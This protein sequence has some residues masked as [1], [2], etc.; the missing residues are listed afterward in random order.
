MKVKNNETRIGM[1][2]LFM[3]MALILLM[4]LFGCDKSSQ[5]K[6]QIKKPSGMS[7]ELYVYQICKQA[8]QVRFMP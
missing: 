3:I 7:N 4:G 6:T 2:I 5:V 1:I 8:A